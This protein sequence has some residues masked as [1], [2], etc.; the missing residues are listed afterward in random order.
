MDAASRDV[1][2]YANPD[3]THC[4]QAAIRMVV[5][6][7]RP[8][9]EYSWTQLDA[10]TGKVDGYGTWPFAGLMWLHEQGLDV[11][12][13]ELMD[14]SRFARE[15]RS[16]VAEFCPELAAPLPPDLSSEQTAA[17]RFVKLVRCETRIP[18]LD[19][20]RDFLAAGYLAICNVNSRLLNGRDGYMGHF[21]VV[22]SCDA[23]GLVLHDPGPPGEAR[24]RVP[25]GTFE[26]AWAY[27]TERV[28]S[29]VAVRPQPRRL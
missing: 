14:N 26:K 27:P 1:P 17:A 23:T 4:F 3:D 7:F 6:C 11:R 2:F 8:A 28:K 21:V 20:V 19:D 5:K 25:I 24:R 13:I 12:N 29:L 18:D 10:I 9:E 15:G 22:T 16:Y